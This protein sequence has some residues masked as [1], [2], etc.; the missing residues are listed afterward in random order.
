MFG[1]DVLQCTTL[2]VRCSIIASLMRAIIESDTF[3]AKVNCEQR[4]KEGERNPE[5]Q[6]SKNSSTIVGFGFRLEH[7]DWVVVL[8]DLYCVG[9]LILRLHIPPQTEEK[10]ACVWFCVLLGC[11]SALLR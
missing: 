7:Y 3:S 8:L 6:L 9:S 1:L 10:L 5:T 11:P 4:Q 2:N